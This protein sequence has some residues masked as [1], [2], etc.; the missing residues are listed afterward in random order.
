MR[1]TTN[2]FGET[3]RAHV[4]M[5]SALENELE[6]RKRREKGRIC[7]WKRRRGDIRAYVHASERTNERERERET[8]GELNEPT[9]E[10]L[11]NF[12]KTHLR[13]VFLLSE[14]PPIQ[15]DEGSAA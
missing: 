4:D 12:L 13:P 6:E 1:E 8:D 15:A 9:R 3:F 14:R 10:P 11:A 5:P 7:A 2:H